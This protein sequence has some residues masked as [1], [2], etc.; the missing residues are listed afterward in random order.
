[1]KHWEKGRSVLKTSVSS[2]NKD[3]IDN[4]K[5][6]LKLILTN[7]E[8]NITLIVNR[9]IKRLHSLKIGF[10]GKV[11]RCLD[12]NIILFCR[13]DDFIFA[14]EKICCLTNAGGKDQK[15]RFISVQG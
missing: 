14:V 7:I 15:S 10:F 11:Y 5:Q 6:S 1:M 4:K 13:T 3:E 2:S 8:Y 9:V 12:C